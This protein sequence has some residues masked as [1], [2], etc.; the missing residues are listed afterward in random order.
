[1]S[2]AYYGYF[3]YFLF[4][5]YILV[6][7]NLKAHFMTILYKNVENQYPMDT[8]RK[9]IKLMDGLKQLKH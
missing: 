5:K 9:K 3:R 2:T 7:H 1:M 4:I 6:I 8:H